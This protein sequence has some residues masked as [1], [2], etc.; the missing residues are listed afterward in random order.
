MWHH[1]NMWQWG[2]V[3]AGR[4]A[5][6]RGS[7]AGMAQQVLVSYRVK[8][9]LTSKQLP[10]EMSSEPRAMEDEQ[11]AGAQE[12]AAAPAAAAPAAAPSNP[13]SAKESTEAAKAEQGQ[14]GGG[15]K[16]RK[17][18]LPL[19]GYSTRRWVMSKVSKLQTRVGTAPRACA[20]NMHVL[21][22]QLASA[23]PYLSGCKRF[24][25]LQRCAPIPGSPR[26]PGSPA[27]LPPPLQSAAAA[28]AC[29][30]HC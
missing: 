11:A 23:S 8:L 15:N 19:A 24:P 4:P 26:T 7:P 13:T 27:P 29:R 6:C 20:L 1:G 3:E 18:R 5:W 22:V 16:K 17:V 21:A 12:A 14:G 9:L 25:N 28:T 2:E 30:C 10:S